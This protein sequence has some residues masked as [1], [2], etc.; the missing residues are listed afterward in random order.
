MSGS[1]RAPAGPRVTTL[2]VVAAMMLAGAVLLAADPGPPHHPR[3]VPQPAQTV[4]E[5]FPP[6]EWYVPDPEPAMPDWRPTPRA[7]QGSR[8]PVTV[9]RHDTPRPRVAPRPLPGPRAASPTPTPAPTPDPVSS[10]TPPAK[11][12]CPK[13]PHPPPC[14]HKPKAGPS[15]HP[16]TPPRRHPLR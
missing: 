5:G 12:D 14:G 4:D 1:H 6:P 11:R 8:T 7:F 15:D 13:A 2:G 3:A 9:A 10:E 16:D